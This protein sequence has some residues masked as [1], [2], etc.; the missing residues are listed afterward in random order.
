MPVILR[1][2]GCRFFFYSNEGDPS[3]P[4]HVHV[5]KAE[6]IAKFWIAAQVSVAESY[7][8]TSAELR[9][10]QKVARNNVELIERCW[11]EYFSD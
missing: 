5:Q 11:H 3:E 8:F 2:K 10:L 4:I 6:R 1:Y 7:G 9:E